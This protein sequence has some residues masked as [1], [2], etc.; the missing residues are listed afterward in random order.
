[1]YILLTNI[2]GIKTRCR[3]QISQLRKNVPSSL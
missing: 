3:K 1:M 2:Q